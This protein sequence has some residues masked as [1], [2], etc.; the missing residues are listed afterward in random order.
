MLE[1][2]RKSEE[3]LLPSLKNFGL[4]FTAVF[5]LIGVAHVPFG[6]APRIWALALS[7]AFLIVTF[8]APGLLVPI[9]R[10]WFRFGLLLHAI[11]NP[12]VLGVIYFG[13]LVP[14]ALAMRAAGKQF[15]K[16]DRQPEA[17]SYWIDRTPPGPEPASISRQ[18]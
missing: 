2:K 18:F 4:T 11:V 12:L 5:A 14:M 17:A 1:T 3:L 16:L 8:T 10:I 6:G 15:L 9:N 7:A 13:L